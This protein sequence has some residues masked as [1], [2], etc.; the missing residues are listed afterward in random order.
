VGTFVSFC[1]L[2]LLLVVSPMSSYQGLEGLGRQAA[3]QVET[4]G[5]KGLVVSPMQQEQ[6][7]KGCSKSKFDAAVARTYDLA[8]S[9]HAETTTSHVNERNHFVLGTWSKRT[10]GGLTNRDRVLLAKIYGKAESVFEYTP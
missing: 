4:S 5:D 2:Y 10:D 1:L 3:G 9:S 7:D 6:A 8:V